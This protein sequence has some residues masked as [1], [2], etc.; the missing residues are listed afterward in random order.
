MT[1]CG[2]RTDDPGFFTPCNPCHC[3]ALVVAEQAE[4]AR[5]APVTAPVTTAAVLLVQPADP[6]APTVDEVRQ[7][8]DIMRF[9][10]G[11]RVTP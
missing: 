4:A 1:V 8:F 9:L 3:K 6:S 11:F 2:Q 10:A 7:G 5:S